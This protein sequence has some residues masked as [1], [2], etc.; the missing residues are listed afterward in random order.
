[1]IRVGRYDAFDKWQI[2]CRHWADPGAV[3]DLGVDKFNR[4]RLARWQAIA[5]A[6]G[7]AACAEYIR[8]KILA[9]L[10]GASTDGDRPDAEC[11]R[12]IAALLQQ[13]AEW[14]LQARV[15]E[16]A[17]RI[18]AAGFD[19]PVDNGLPPRLLQRVREA[20]AAGALRALRWTEDPEEVPTI[21]IIREQAP[22]A[23]PHRAIRGCRNVLC[24]FS[25]WFYGRSDVIHV[26][27]AA[28][29]RAT[30]V[31]LHGPSLDDMRLIYPAHWRYVC[32]DFRDFL[33]QAEADD[34]S[35]DLI[36]SDPFRGV[37]TAIAWELLPAIMRLCSKTF[38]TNYFVEMFKEL[39]VAA[40]D[41]DGLSRAVRERTGVDATVTEIVLRNPDVSWV[42]M[43][44]R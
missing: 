7:A 36:V 31:D 6:A 15:A 28:P 13:M 33:A 14:E 2:L 27:D 18:T 30:L 9:L 12:E 32:A 20:F 10:A 21:E 26:H 8:M 1:M 22:A 19:A 11:N 44:K 39:G 42:V 5:A 34:I 4:P 25:A 43:C 35:Y 24:L 40:N 41:V 17:A 16:V 23:F 38:V 37:E 3:G 29:E